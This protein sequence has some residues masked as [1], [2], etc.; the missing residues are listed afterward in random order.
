MLIQEL[1][2]ASHSS[3]QKTEFAQLPWSWRLSVMTKKLSLTA[4]SVFMEI[5][6]S[7]NICSS[8]ASM[9]AQSAYEDDVIQL[10]APEKASQW[11]WS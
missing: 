3:H 4:H 10:K 2:T 1:L 5:T 6:E 7:L 8:M 11:I 9:Q